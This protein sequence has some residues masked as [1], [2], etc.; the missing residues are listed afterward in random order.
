MYQQQKHDN[1]SGIDEMFLLN[2]KKGIYTC[3]ALSL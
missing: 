3:M 1:N 2:T